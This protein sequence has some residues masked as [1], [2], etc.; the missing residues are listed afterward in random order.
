MKLSIITINYN[1][2]EGLRKTLESVC[3][4]TFRDYEWIV[5]DGGSNDGSREL[6]EANSADITYWVSEPDNGIYHAMNKGIAQAK[7][8]FCQFL[9]SGDYYISADTLKKV[10][11]NKDLADVNYGDQ[12]CIKEGKVVEKR[13]YPDKMGLSYLL[14]APLGHQ[15]SFFRTSAIKEHPY[16]EK[17]TISADRAFFLGLYVFGYQFKHIQQPIAYFDTE[18][19]GSNAKTLAERRRQFHAIKREFFSEQVINDIEHLMK[20]A[21]NYKFVCRVAPLRWIYRLSRTIQRKRDK[22]KRPIH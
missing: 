12:W 15:A 22:W 5:I 8:E 11:S 18:G 16:K 1:N 17:Y 20:E 14:K 9:N 21:D 4:Q 3:A 13:I 10:F 19:I 6:I 7:G 2:L